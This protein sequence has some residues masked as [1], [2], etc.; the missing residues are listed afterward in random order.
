LLRR[1][2]D[3]HSPLLDSLANG[4]REIR[5]KPLVGEHLRLDP[6]LE[7]MLRSRISRRV[8]AEHHINLAN[9]RPGYIGVVC[10][11]LSL[12]DSVD[13]A[14]GRCR[15]V[16]Q[17]TFGTAPDIFVGGDVGLRVPYI[18]AH[19][20]Y[21]LYELLKNA[22]RAVTE[23]HLRNSIKTGGSVAIPHHAQD[24][25]PPIHV[26]I[27]GGRDDVTIRVSDQGGGIPAEH[28]SN[29]WE[30]G[31]TD[32]DKS[33]QYSDSPGGDGGLGPGEGLGLDSGVMGHAF[34][35]VGNALA[36][37]PGGGG[38]FRMAG[39]GFG[40]PLSRLYARYFGGDLRLVSMPG[41]GVD[42]FLYLK[43]LVAEGREWRENTEDESS[44]S[45]MESV[46]LGP[47]TMVAGA[48]RTSS[49]LI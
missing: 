18:P 20:D 49:S 34:G 24:R 13:F 25:V 14:A 43:G 29:V 41:Y 46:L 11:D 27:C 16:C 30:F 4:L 28:L 12:G 10:T 5:Q 38:S 17:E 6:F 40:L 44:S 37:E 36:A 39:L 1:L 8:L 35:G 2:V 31:W 21:M 22:A 47:D 26:K 19:I 9:G 45:S 23:R 3:E 42:A 32:I 48:E 15:Q 7:A 33:M